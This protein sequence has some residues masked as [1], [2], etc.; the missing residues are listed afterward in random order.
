MKQQKNRTSVTSENAGD[1]VELENK[2][3]FAGLYDSMPA[4][5]MLMCFQ[6][7]KLKVTSILAFTSSE[8]CEIS[9]DHDERKFLKIASY[10]IF[11]ELLMETRP[12]G[13]SLKNGRTSC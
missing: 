12:L 11:P 10:V 3:L 13:K 5:M 2:A 8:S 9:R 6:S 4:H 7:C 1:G